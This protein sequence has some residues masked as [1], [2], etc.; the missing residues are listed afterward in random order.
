MKG[1][2]K[3]DREE[4]RCAWSTEMKGKWFLCIQLSL[5]L[6]P[7]SKTFLVSCF[8]TFLAKRF[9]L[10]FFQ[11][12]TLT[13]EKTNWW[14]LLSD[15][16][17]FYSQLIQCSLS[18]VLFPFSLSFHFSSPFLVPWNGSR[19][20]GKR[21]QNLTSLANIFQQRKRGS[22]NG[23]RVKFDARNCTSNSNSPSLSFFPSSHSIITSCVTWLTYLQ[24]DKWQYIQANSFISMTINLTFSSS[25]VQ[26]FLKDWFT[27]E[28]ER[29]N[30]KLRTENL[31]LKTKWSCNQLFSWHPSHKN[32]SLLTWW[33]IIMVQLKQIDE[34]WNV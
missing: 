3:I 11:A 24:S 15:T 2:K 31:G 1:R 25:S 12:V 29:E 17:K 23:T 28:R 9:I 13:C 8:S 21:R 20:E 32:V 22:G 6:L 30:Q 10:S 34:A 16:I 26:Q 5:S 4:A 18:L 27:R 33:L 19:M 14:H 7:F